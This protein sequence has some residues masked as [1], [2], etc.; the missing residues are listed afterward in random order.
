MPITDFE[1]KLSVEEQFKDSEVRANI[2]KKLLITRY[3]ILHLYSDLDIENK[4]PTI[5]QIGETNA[6]ATK[7]TVVLRSFIIFLNFIRTKAEEL[8]TEIER[9]EMLLPAEETL[10]W[11]VK[12][13]EQDLI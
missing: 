9:K 2:I 10:S 13:V 5:E 3:S 4:L 7:L 8:S 11:L 1:K 12:L 6:D